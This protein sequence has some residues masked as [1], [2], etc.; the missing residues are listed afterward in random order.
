MSLHNPFAHKFRTRSGQPIVPPP[1]QGGLL[2]Q[3]PKGGL[4]GPPSS[5]APEPQSLLDKILGNLGSPGTQFALRLLEQAG[6]QPF[7]TSFGQ[8]ISRA[9]L[10]TVHQQQRNQLASALSR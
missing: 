6:P 3:G 10:G 9:G 4:Q 1:I 5:L 8:A 7:P 2:P